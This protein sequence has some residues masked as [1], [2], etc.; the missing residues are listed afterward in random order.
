MSAAPSASSPMYVA[1]T[2]TNELPR[3]GSGTCGIGGKDMRRPTEVTSF[4]VPSTHSRQAFSTSEARSTGK[5]R[6]PAYTSGT[7]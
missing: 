2:R 3:S 6:T 5:K 1:S 4:G 7:G